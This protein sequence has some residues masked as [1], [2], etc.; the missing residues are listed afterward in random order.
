MDAVQTAWS[1]FTTCYA[2]YE[3]VS[4]AIEINAESKLWNVQM[5]VERARFEVWCRTLGFLDEKT[6]SPKSLATADLGIN[7]GS[8]SDIVEVE[9]ANKLICDLLRAISSA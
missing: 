7:N 8:L 1:V 4:E 5:R 3:V 2:S 9:T 6:G